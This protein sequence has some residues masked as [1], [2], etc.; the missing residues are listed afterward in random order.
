MEIHIWDLS[1]YRQ[2]ESREAGEVTKGMSPDK[3]EG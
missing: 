2:L 3:E 1:K